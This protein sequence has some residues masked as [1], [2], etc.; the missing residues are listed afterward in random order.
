MIEILKLFV[1]TGVLIIGFFIGKILANQT[2][3]ELKDG[4]KYF[5]ILVWVGLIG[6]FIGL[7]I[8]SDVLLF[9]MFFIAIVTSRSIVNR[10][11]SKKNKNDKH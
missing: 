7:V 2:K 3:D 9:T 10:K 6:G 11:N 5:I 8:G 4:K 1:G